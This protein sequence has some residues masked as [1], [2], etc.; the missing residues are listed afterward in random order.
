MTGTPPGDP[1][2]PVSTIGMVGIEAAAR[3]VGASPSAI[4]AWERQGLIRPRRTSGDAR[5]YAPEDLRRLADIRRWRTQEGLNAAAIRRLLSEPRGRND[6]HAGPGSPPPARPSPAADTAPARLAVA[7]RLLAARRARGLTLKAAASASGL[8]T[9]F[10]SAL[11]RGLTG[12]SVVA[13]H[14]LVDTYETTV[15][16]LLDAADAAPARL[17][18][19]TARKVVEASAG[20]RIENLAERSRSLEPQLFVLAPGASSEGQYSHAGEEFMFVLEGCLAVWLGEAE[21]YRL[22]AGDALT[23]P[24]TIPHRFE[25][26]DETRLLWVNTPPTF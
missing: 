14:R 18:P 15:A 13:L 21:A 20:V 25:A 7:D 22:G 23:F 19:A 24:S 8:S 11:E 10:I 12:V 17:V 3:S 16:E 2:G 6:G 9:S 4:R 1:E 5:R 26:L